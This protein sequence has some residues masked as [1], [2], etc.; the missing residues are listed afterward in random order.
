METY[1][2]LIICDD[3]NNVKG[4]YNVFAVFAHSGLTLSP[5][6]SPPSPMWHATP[7]ES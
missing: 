4:I 1:D 3:G 5:T 7:S 6:P 2:T